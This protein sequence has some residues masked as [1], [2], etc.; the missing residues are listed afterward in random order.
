MSSLQVETEIHGVCFR[1]Q[2]RLRCE[3]PA[4]SESCPPVPP[5]A[6][7]HEPEQAKTTRCP[8]RHVLE[9]LPASGPC[10]WKMHH[11]RM[12]TCEVWFQEW[13]PQLA[14]SGHKRFSKYE[15]FGDQ[16]YEKYEQIGDHKYDKYEQFG[17]QKYEKYDNLGIK[18]MKNTNNV[19]IKNMKNNETYKQF[20]DQ[21]Y[22][23]YEQFGDQKYE[24]YEQFGDQ[25]YVLKN[26]QFGDQT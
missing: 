14:I 24:T 16:Q 7:S 2:K 4:S 22:E 19:G 9:R 18:H 21:T 11:K 12:Q 17:D 8:W 10:V 20:G 6:I 26:E 3:S 23:K 5:H 1:L 13:V 15:Q 25:Q